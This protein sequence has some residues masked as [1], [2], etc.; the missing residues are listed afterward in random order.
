MERTILFPGISAPQVTPFHENGEI[1]YEE[2]RRLTRFLAEGGVKGIFVCGTTGEFV[3]L[4]MEERKQLLKAAK[5]G[6]GPETKILYNITALNLKDAEELISWAKA[7]G[8]H[9]VSLTA[10]YYHSYDARALISYFTKLADLAYPIPV[11]LYNIPSIVSDILRNKRSLTE[12]D[13]K[14]LRD[15]HI[16]WRD[17]GFLL[18]QSGERSF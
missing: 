18:L 2:Y 9:G 12:E 8:V 3:N 16:H 13:R 10:P 7:E 6:A 15:C 11:Y 1:N 14:R 4:T 17:G 5:R